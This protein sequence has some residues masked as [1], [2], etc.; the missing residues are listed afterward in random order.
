[1]ILIRYGVIL[2]V[3]DTLWGRINWESVYVSL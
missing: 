2:F 3:Q 1:M